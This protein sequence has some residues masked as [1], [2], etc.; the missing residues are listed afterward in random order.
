MDILKLNKGQFAWGYCCNTLYA[1]KPGGEDVS[2]WPGRC[3]KTANRKRSRHQVWLHRQWRIYRG[4]GALR[5][6]PPVPLAKAKIY[7]K[8][9]HIFILWMNKLYILWWLPKMSQI[10]NL[11][12]LYQLNQGFPTWGTCTPR[13]TFAYLRGYIFG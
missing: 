1:T 11:K 6:D 7:G 8:I 13:G 5:H 3:L 4:G 9:D 12:S 10:Y 2:Y